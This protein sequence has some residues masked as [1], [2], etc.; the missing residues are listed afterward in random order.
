MLF[1]MLNKRTMD[2]PLLKGAS[3]RPKNLPYEL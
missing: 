2:D 3:D 1:L